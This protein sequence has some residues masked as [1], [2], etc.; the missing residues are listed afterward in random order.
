MQIIKENAVNLKHMAFLLALNSSGVKPITLHKNRMI[1]CVRE[2]NINKLPIQ[3][4]TP[5]NKHN[6]CAIF[7]RLR[8]C[9]KKFTVNTMSTSNRTTPWLTDKNKDN[10]NNKISLM[11]ACH[12]W[13]FFTSNLVEK[14]Q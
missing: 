8:Y 5:V 14:T 4:D 7:Y 13:D 6:C 1:D 3:D 2:F 9:H 12:N 10:K 11:L